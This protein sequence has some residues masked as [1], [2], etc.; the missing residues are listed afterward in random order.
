MPPMVSQESDSGEAAKGALN[1]RPLAQPDSPAMRKPT[2][3]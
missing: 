3:S 2:L 1:G